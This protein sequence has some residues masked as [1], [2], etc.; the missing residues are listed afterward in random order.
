MGIFSIYKVLCIYQNAN[1]FYTIYSALLCKT[2]GNRFY[3]FC[4]EQICAEINNRDHFNCGC[5]VEG[6]AEKEGEGMEREKERWGRKSLEQS[7]VLEYHLE[8]ENSV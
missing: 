3:I 4:L 5:I 6:R 1:T 7:E 2:A 8:G